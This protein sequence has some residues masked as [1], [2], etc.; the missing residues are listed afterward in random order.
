MFLN[1]VF[2]QLSQINE[3]ELPICRNKAAI[4]NTKGMNVKKMSIFAVL[5]LIFT[6]RPNQKG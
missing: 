6:I 3:N 4:P 5:F 2:L 1:L